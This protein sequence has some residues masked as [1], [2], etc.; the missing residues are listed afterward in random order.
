MCIK[1]AEDNLVAENRKTT[2]DAPAARTNVG[3]QL[4][5][6]EVDVPAGTAGEGEGALVLSR[7]VKDAI[8]DQGS[9]FKLTRSCSLIDPFRNQAARVAWIDLIERAEA[10]SG[11]VPGVGQP[12]LRL[13][14]GVEQP[15]ERDL[16]PSLARKRADQCR[17]REKTYQCPEKRRSKSSTQPS[18]RHFSTISATQNLSGCSSQ[19]SQGQRVLRTSAATC[20]AM[21]R[22][23]H[24]APTLIKYATMSPRSLS[25]NTAASYLGIMDSRLLWNERSL[26][27]SSR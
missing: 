4:A 13:L 24:F 15:F 16:R 17:D 26:S 22:H 12:V 7:G 8:D 2:I 23:A 27:F 1:S 18:R 19:K 6:V 3:R 11:V 5:L 21:G 20:Q 14:G 10:A 9:G 25:S